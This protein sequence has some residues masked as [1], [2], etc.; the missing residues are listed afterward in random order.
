MCKIETTV[1]Q[2]KLIIQLYADGAR[3]KDMLK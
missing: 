2:N 1:P 3:E